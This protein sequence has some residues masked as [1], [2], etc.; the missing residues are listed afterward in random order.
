MIATDDRNRMQNQSAPGVQ[1]HRYRLVDFVDFPRPGGGVD[2]VCR[3]AVVEVLDDEGVVPIRHL[4]SMFLPMTPD[5]LFDFLG[6][7][8]LNEVRE[9]WIRDGVPP[10]AGNRPIPNQQ[11]YPPHALEYEITIR[12]ITPAPGTAP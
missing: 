7:K 9:D 11:P 1:S 12:R 6:A 3:L 2:E 10:Q 4:E 8:H 5:E